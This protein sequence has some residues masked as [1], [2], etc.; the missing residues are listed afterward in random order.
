MTYRT[1]PKGRNRWTVASSQGK[2]IAE[3]SLS[4]G[5]Y[6]IE[7]FKKLT[8][9]E[10]GVIAVFVMELRLK[11]CGEP[12]RNS[13]EWLLGRVDADLDKLAG[14]LEARGESPE[15][16]ELLD[17]TAMKLQEVREA[18]RLLMGKSKKA[19]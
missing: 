7:P 10:S 9:D 5:Q 8:K 13:T 16:V 4:K 14:L 6:A 19:A 1:A 2:T 18:L 17:A 15:L 3:V 11:A 12:P